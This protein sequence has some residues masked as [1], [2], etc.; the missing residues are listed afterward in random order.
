MNCTREAV[1]IGSHR[2]NNL[3]LSFLLVLGLT[4]FQSVNGFTQ[5][6]QITGKSLYEL[7]VDT[8][9]VPKIQSVRSFSLAEKV[10]SFS[11]LSQMSVGAGYETPRMY[12]Y[13]NLAFFCRLEVKIEKASKIPVR[14]RLGSVP[15]VDYLEGKRTSY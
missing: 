6:T 13:H 15:Y 8:I 10:A 9:V 1:R 5:S 11:F 2:K 12:N 3:Y 14:F 4:V 7:R